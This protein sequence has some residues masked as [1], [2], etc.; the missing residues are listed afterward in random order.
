MPVP[1]LA[2]YTLLSRSGVADL[3]KTIRLD[4]TQCSHGVDSMQTN[5]AA[6]LVR[7]FVNLVRKF[8]RIVDTQRR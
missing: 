4:H 2:A 7:G 8:V 1:A 5:G 6:V 3:P